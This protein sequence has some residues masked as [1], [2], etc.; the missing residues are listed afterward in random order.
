MESKWEWKARREI[1]M[2][3]LTVVLYCMVTVTENVTKVLLQQGSVNLMSQ[4]YS[5]KD[6]RTAN[7][8]GSTFKST[9]S[10][11]DHE[12]LFFF[13]V[14]FMFYVYMQPCVWAM[15]HLSVSTYKI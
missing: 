6:A 10:L 8:F 15:T 13:L 1:E 11:I 7:W 3:N 9:S 4:S 14:I 5:L 12:G 2:E